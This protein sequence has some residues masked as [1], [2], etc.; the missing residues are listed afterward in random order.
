MA[1]MV[2]YNYA[3]MN[4][5]AGGIQMGGHTAQALLDAAISNEAQM[6]SHF[7]GAAAETARACLATY[8]Q[9]A[10][11]M[12]EVVNRAHVSYADGTAQMAASEQAQSAAFPG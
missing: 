6:L 12:I 3:A 11:D 10:M 9:A 7:N 5:V 1:D 8:K 2:H 4:E